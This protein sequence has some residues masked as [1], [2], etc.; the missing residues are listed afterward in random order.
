MSNLTPGLLDALALGAT[1]LA[2]FHYNQRLIV[3]R[4]TLA[5][6]RWLGPPIG[7]G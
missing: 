7:E 5:I 3:P 2:G 4:Q 6:I 1:L